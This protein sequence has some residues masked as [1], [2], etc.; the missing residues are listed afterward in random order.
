MKNYNVKYS[1]AYG[2]AGNYAETA[3]TCGPGF[4]LLKQYYT[5]MYNFSLLNDERECS[6]QAIGDFIDGKLC[7]GYN[8]LAYCSGNFY[9][10][11]CGAGISPLICNKLQKNSQQQSGTQKCKWFDC[12]KPYPW[13]G[14]AF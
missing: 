9:T 10:K 6:K 3:Y 4:N 7:K 14:T 11:A 5:C 8:D 13:N 12:S 2:Y 1:D